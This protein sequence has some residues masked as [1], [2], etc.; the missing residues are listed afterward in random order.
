MSV[1]ENC[2]KIYFK[3]FNFE[4]RFI[5]FIRFF[6]FIWVYICYAF[7][8]VEFCTVFIF[9]FR[10][11]WGNELVWQRKYSKCVLKIVHTNSGHEAFFHSIDAD[12]SLAQYYITYMILL[13][14]FKNYFWWLFCVWIIISQQSNANPTNNLSSKNLFGTNE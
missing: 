11:S 14:I 13:F 9:S 3:N 10:I 7:F 1:G 8:H 12:L 2:K 4:R 6:K 5:E